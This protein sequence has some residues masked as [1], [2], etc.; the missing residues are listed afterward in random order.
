MEKGKIYKL[1]IWN[2]KHVNV[3]SKGTMQQLFL[4]VR[5]SDDERKT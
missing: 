1:S 5:T 4:K 3:E 2:K